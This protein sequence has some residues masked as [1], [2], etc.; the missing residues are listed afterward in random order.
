MRFA[1]K[2]TKAVQE[3]AALYVFVAIEAGRI[4]HEPAWHSGQRRSSRPGGVHRRG[5]E[6]DTDRLAAAANSSGAET[7]QRLSS[8]SRGLAE[9]L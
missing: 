7:V 2:K 3:G 1:A 4:S 8:E 9:L 6:W 5:S